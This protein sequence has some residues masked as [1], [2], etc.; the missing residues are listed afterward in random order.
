MARLISMQIRNFKSIE[1]V[2]ISFDK[3][4]VFVGPNASGKSNIIDSISFVSEALNHSLD[5]AIQKRGGISVVRRNTRHGASDITIDLKL[6]LAD[7]KEASYYFK[8]VTERNGNFRVGEEKC[9]IY[10]SLQTL[11]EYDVSEGSFVIQVK[12][13]SPK[14]EADRLAL[15]SIAAHPDY[16]EL[17]DFLTNMRVFSLLPNEMK[18]WQEPTSELKLNRE[19]TNAAVVLKQLSRKNPDAYERI[20]QLLGGF[21]PSISKVSTHSTI[22]AQK[23]TILFQQSSPKFTEPLV[24]NASSMSDGTLRILGI[25]L[26]LGDISSNSSLIAIEE[27]ELTVHPALVSKISEFMI[28]ES[29]KI[30]IVLTTHSPELLDSRIQADQIRLVWLDEQMCTK[31]DV[32]PEKTKAVINRHTLTA[33]E[34]LKSDE[35][36]PRN[37]TLDRYTN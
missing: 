35:L 5:W 3:L 17:Y 37:D 33:G 16:R 12:G 26:A 14:L 29:E 30:Q 32:L 23:D 11:A 20:C 19:G 36:H 18:K 9:R 8:L 15:T 34:L 31:V 21:I 22:P 24:F 7:H 4:T 10:E 27:P 25:L 6:E 1:Y 28:Q 13:I 2:N